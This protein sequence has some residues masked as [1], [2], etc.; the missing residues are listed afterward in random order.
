[1][2][3]SVEGTGTVAEEAGGTS[4]PSVQGAV[5]AVKVSVV[6]AGGGV[7]TAGV[8]VGVT[9]AGVLVGVFPGH[10]KLFMSVL[11]HQKMSRHLASSNCQ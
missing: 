7:A 2:V 4:E 5:G 6:G 10:C 9:T 11:L 3:E 8:L 1:V